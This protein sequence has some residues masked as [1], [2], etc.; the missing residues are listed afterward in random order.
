M[1]HLTQGNVL[2]AEIIEQVRQTWS[3]S[4]SSLQPMGTK[5]IE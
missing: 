2:E 5:K 4:S 3:L 1:K